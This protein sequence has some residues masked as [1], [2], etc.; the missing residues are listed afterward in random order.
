MFNKPMLFKRVWVLV[1]GLNEQQVREEG[2][3]S[4]TFNQ[5]QSTYSPRQQGICFYQI[6]KPYVCGACS[7]LIR[8]ASTSTQLPFVLETTTIL[9]GDAFAFSIFLLVKKHIPEQEIES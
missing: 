2:E 3:N 5:P 9:V 6:W 4:W 8:G 1:E 7:K